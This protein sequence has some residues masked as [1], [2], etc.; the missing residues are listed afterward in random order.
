MSEDQTARL[1]RI[2]TVDDVQI[3]L[4]W[5]IGGDKGHGQW[6]PARLR[7]ILTDHAHAG[8]LKY[9]LGTHWIER[10]PK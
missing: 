2:Q 7:Q 10:S 1:E 8:N 3:R 5:E 6:Q 4:A 9:G